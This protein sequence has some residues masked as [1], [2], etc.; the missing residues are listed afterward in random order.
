MRPYAY[1]NRPHRAGLVNGQ[2][3]SLLLMTF[4]VTH[5]FSVNKGNPCVCIRPLTVL[6]RIPTGRAAEGS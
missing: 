2:L 1:I 5:H 4:A 6:L 3:V